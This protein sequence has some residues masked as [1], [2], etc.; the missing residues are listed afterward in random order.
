MR[1]SATGAAQFDCALDGTLVYVPGVA[2]GAPHR[3]AWLDPDGQTEWANLRAS[4]QQ[5]PRLAPDGRRV[6][7]LAGSTGAGDVWVHDLA[8][9]AST[10]ITTTAQNA[11]PVWS[12]DGLWVYYTTFDRVG[13]QS[14]VMR[15]RADGLSEPQSLA[16]IAGRAR[17]AWVDAS[18]RWAIVDT[19]D[20][21]SGR[22]DIVR[23][24]FATGAIEP[25]VATPEDEYGSAVSPDGGWL[26]YQSAPTGRPEVYVR[27]LTGRRV[28]RQLTTEGGEE[29]RWSV[30][31]REIFFRSAT[32]LYAMA[33]DATGVVRPRPRLLLEGVY[34]VSG[35]VE[36]SR[37]YDV[38]LSTGR[39]LIVRAADAQAAQVVRVAMHWWR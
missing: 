24:T 26:A 33:F 19:V 34:N 5:D 35:D 3:L 23:L 38:H 4:S 15:Q 18:Q 25:L 16:P 21:S 1:E 31:G 7:M 36:G 10:R 22:A 39:L 20:S 9:G 37:N 11:A 6:A 17:V 8:T 13:M 2:E 14:V 27:D 32:R 28:L 30:D 12:A 29:P